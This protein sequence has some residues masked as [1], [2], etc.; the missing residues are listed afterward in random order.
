MAPRISGVTVRSILKSPYIVYPAG[1]LAIV[2][3]YTDIF[4]LMPGEFNAHNTDALTALY[5]VI[6]TRKYARA[7]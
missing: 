1:I 7:K 3:I 4:M 2:L 5:W 6:V